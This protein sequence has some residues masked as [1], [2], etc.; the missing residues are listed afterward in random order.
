MKTKITFGLLL[1]VGIISLGAC[2][3]S[4]SNQNAN[5]NA[6]TPAHE[7]PVGGAAPAG[8]KF[9]FRG[10]ITTSAN[11]LRIEMA[12]VREGERLNGNYFYPKVGKNI[13]L[14]GT[15]DKSGNVELKETDENGKETGVFKGKWKPA[16]DSP[17]PNLNEIDGKW[18]K[19]DGSKETPFLV[20]QQ[21]IEFSGPV[22]VNPKVIREANKEKHYTVE[23]EYPQIEGDAR[24]DKF[25][26]EA[27]TMVAKDVAAFKSSETAPEPDAVSDVPA[28]TGDS[29]EDIGYHIRYATDD[30]ISVEFMED[31]YS[32][33]AAHGNQITTVLNYDVKNGKKLA[34]ADLFNPKSNY[35][36]IISGYCIKELKAQKQ[37]DKQTMLSDDM[38]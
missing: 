5:A 38:I 14:N 23:A 29:T 34:L 2:R 24:F 33:G 30:L 6:A 4:A 13:N 12:L 35:L 21:P 3:K 27:R 15:I 32:R 25:N 16:T 37:K 19:P 10:T 26:R 28:E 31:S 11:K 7:A 8:E 9:F 22:R 36:S 17:D 18:S 20:V 1:L